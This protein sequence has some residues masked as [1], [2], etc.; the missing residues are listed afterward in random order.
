MTTQAKRATVYL[1]PDL[2][3]ALRLKAVETSRSISDLVNE[4]IREALAED[5]EDIAA[6]EQRAGDPLIS[7]D[8]MVK[9]LKRDGRI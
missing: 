9:R 6:F 7:Y 8:E 1:D 5:A 2:H 4:A 3:K